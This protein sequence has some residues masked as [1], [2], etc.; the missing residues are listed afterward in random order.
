VL[1]GRAEA[2]ARIDEGVLRRPVPAM[3]Q[4]ARSMSRRRATQSI[5][6]RA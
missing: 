3:G 6:L 1:P 2:R 5:T 4:A